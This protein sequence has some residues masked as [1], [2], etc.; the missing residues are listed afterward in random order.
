MCI[1]STINFTISIFNILIF[2]N[3]HPLA[4][5][6]ILRISFTVFLFVSFDEQRFV[7][8][9][10][11]NESITINPLTSVE[12]LKE[13]EEKGEKEENKGRKGKW[14]GKD[15]DRTWK[16]E[17]RNFVM[18]KLIHPTTIPVV[19]GS[20]SIRISLQPLLIFVP[21]SSFLSLL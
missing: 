17:R 16:T 13:V 19:Q 7:Q 6:F 9:F 8:F 12:S 21:L 20:F 18:R 14:R 5:H 15:K 11:P 2:L 10:R 1:L 3:L 4:Y